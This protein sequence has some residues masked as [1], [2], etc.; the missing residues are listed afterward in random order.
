M[1]NK[2]MAGLAGVMLALF[3]GQFIGGGVDQAKAEQELAGKTY[4]Y[5]CCNSCGA[6]LGN[7]PCHPSS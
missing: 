7:T 6:R 2:I 1:R 3:A 4:V 5:K